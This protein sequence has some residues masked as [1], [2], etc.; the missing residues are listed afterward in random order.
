MIFR[1]L[2]A[3]FAFALCASA[4]QAQSTPAPEKKPDPTG[5]A[6]MQKGRPKNAKTEITCKEE[7]TFDNATG[8]ATFTKSVFVK[9]PQFNLYCDKL[10]VYMNTQRKGI[11]HAV[12]EGKV[13][14]VQENTSDKGEKTKSIGRAGKMIVYPDKNEAQ[15]FSLPGL[16][17]EGN[18]PQLQQGINNHVATEAATTMTLNRNGSLTTVGGSKTVLV[19]DSSGGL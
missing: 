6:G 12:A 1:V 19:E 4:L 9:D 18:W 5:L 16:P 10:T 3:T 13:V 17:A 2:S 8:V 7:A 15:L 11:D 14:I